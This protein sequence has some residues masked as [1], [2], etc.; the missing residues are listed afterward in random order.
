LTAAAPFGSSAD[1]GAKQAKVNS[2]ARA[3]VIGAIDRKVSMMVGMISKPRIGGAVMMAVEIEYR[4]RRWT[5]E[6]GGDLSGSLGNAFDREGGD[7]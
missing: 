2:E 6:V 5:W 7:S 3:G 1:A 4:S